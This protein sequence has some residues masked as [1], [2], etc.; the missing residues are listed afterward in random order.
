MLMIKCDCGGEEQEKIDCIL[1]INL[2]FHANSVLSLIE[3]S[4]F[5]RG[6]LLEGD[7]YKCAD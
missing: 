3:F 6:P 2:N 4:G 7:K 5:L 1:K